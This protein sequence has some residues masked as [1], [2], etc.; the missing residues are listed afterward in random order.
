MAR[1]G[2]ART[3]VRMVRASTEDLGDLAAVWPAARAACSDPDTADDV[4]VAILVRARLWRRRGKPIPRAGLVTAAVRDAVALA[5]ATPLG[6]LR[7]AEREAVALARFAGLSVDEIAA[8][9]DTDAHDVRARL[10]DGLR[11]IARAGAVTE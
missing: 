9:L 11:A 7:V 2:S 1:R 10:R 6:E 5:P 4:T 3:V 8:A